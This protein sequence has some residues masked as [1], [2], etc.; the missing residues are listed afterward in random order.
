MSH[1]HSAR[2]SDRIAFLIF[3]HNAVRVLNHHLD[4]AY[5]GKWARTE[6]LLGKGG[7]S[8]FTVEIL[9]ILSFQLQISL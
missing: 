7:E 1:S 5:V 9:P 6:R 4:V 3:F 8:E 2:D